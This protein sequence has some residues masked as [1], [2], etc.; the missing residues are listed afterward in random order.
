MNLMNYKVKKM[1]KI[2]TIIMKQ[3][4]DI[5]CPSNCIEADGRWLTKNIYPELYEIFKDCNCV[6]PKKSDITGI[7]NDDSDFKGIF[8]IPN[9]YGKAWII[10]KDE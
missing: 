10:Y 3:S 8:H 6:K 2:G 1:H 9:S 7:K 4:M 5:K